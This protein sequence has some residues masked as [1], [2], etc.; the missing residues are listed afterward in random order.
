MKDVS[1]VFTA[2]EKQGVEVQ[3]G[4]SPV[5]SLCEHGNKRCSSIKGAEFLD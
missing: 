5:A 3:T 1:E 4:Y 2:S